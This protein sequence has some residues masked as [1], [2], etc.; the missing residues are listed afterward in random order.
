[1]DET[2]GRLSNKAGVKATIVLDRA[3][4]AIMKTSG[5]VSSI[6]TTKTLTSLP[7]QPA[8]SFSNEADLA[9]PP[10][11]TQGAEELAAMVWNFVG[12]AGSLVEGLDAEVCF[13]PRAAA[14]TGPE[15]ADAAGNRTSS[16]YYGC[17]LR[18]RSW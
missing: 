3:S 1:M 13:L 6:R 15:R 16:N 14:V 5:L 12:T 9:P 11:E 17:A 10:S 2:L 8:G 4:G 7:S 18:N